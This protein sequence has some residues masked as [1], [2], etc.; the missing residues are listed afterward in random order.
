MRQANNYKNYHKG[1]FLQK[2]NC[3]SMV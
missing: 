2:R 3:G 1:G